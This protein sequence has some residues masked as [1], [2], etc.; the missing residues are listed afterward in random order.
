LKIEDNEAEILTNMV[1]TDNQN[2]L[3]VLKQ[4]KQDLLD[5]IKKLTTADAE[6]K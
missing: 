5:K 4:I 2:P 6:S 1:I 3:D